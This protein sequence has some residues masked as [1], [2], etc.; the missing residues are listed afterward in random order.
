MAKR[1]LA[2][3]ESSRPV[4]AEINLQ[5]DLAAAVKS[6]KNPDAITW[7]A[8]H[9]VPA[10]LAS[11]GTLPVLEAS[12]QVLLA[13]PPAVSAKP[14][15]TAL[16]REIPPRTRIRAIEWL[17][18]ELVPDASL[19]LGPSL[20]ARS[21]P[22][23]RAAV[24]TIKTLD[25]PRAVPILIQGLAAA[26]GIVAAEIVDVLHHF[27][28]HKLGDDARPWEAWWKAKGETWLA[29]VD[30]KRHGPRGAKGDV[31]FYGITSPS[32]R[33]AFVLDR[34]GSMKEPATLE[35]AAAPTTGG[36]PAENLAGLNLLDVAKLQLRRAINRLATD[37]KFNVL[38]YNHK[39]EAWKPAPQLIEASREN[40]AA[41]REW[42]MKQQP[43]GSTALFAALEAA[44][45]YADRFGGAQEDDARY[46]DP[47]VDT[48]FLLSDGAP[49][50]DD[51]KLMS[52]EEIEKAVEA[53]LHANAMTRCV[54]H[55][56]GVGPN[57]NEE[58]MKRLARET[59]GTYVAVGMA[60]GG[61]KPAVK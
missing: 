41:A 4:R 61:G 12:V 20:A 34:S 29:A 36:D 16:A 42:F 28:G 5:G 50:N 7:L 23:R 26:S 43:K 19:H 51:N 24:R 1:R 58:L 30:E 37:V 33:I 39:V 52:A 11:G 2:Y 13:Q 21:V 31:E 59:G 18:L 27:T 15:L 14:I 38:F 8:E 54:V 46:A 25:D 3:E 49:T 22:V 17:A 55:T 6:V 44:L 57:H 56:I 47:G 32:N 40:K 48:I 9:G 35:E 10:L 53:F 60:K 45:K